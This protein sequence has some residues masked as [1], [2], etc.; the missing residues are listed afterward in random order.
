MIHS[1]GEDRVVEECARWV[2]TMAFTQGHIL[3][4]TR[5]MIELAQEACPGKF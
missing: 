2:G 5:L 1:A 3:V 4:L